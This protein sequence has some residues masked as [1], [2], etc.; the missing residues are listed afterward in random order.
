MTAKNRIIKT[1]N[2]ALTEH[3]FNA[4]KIAQRQG[5][6]YLNATSMCKIAQRQI[7]H[8]KSN[9]QTKEFLEALSIDIGIPI[10][11]LIQTQ[12]GGSSSSQGTW[13]HPNVAI[14]LAQWLSPKFAVQVTNWVI[15]WN[16]GG[17]NNQPPTANTPIQLTDGK[18]QYYL[19]VVEYGKTPVIT[20]IADTSMVVD[21]R[22]VDS[23]TDVTHEMFSMLRNMQIAYEERDSV[24]CDTA[25][26]FD[27][28]SKNFQH[29]AQ[30][31]LARQ[32]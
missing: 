30:Q 21:K 10:T 25:S 19:Q 29:I 3:T 20:P 4:F 22:L 1:G 17:N 15:N 11:K 16:S 8:Y 31:H 5:D 24:Y 32:H 26:T 18:K 12:R 6:G 7:G 27:E 2:N 23:M 14:H 28:V 9:N 13:V